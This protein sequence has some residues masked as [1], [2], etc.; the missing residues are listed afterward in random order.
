[1]PLP[2]AGLVHLKVQPEIIARG[3]GLAALV[4]RAMMEAPRKVQAA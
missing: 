2:F 1:M 3:L 4:A